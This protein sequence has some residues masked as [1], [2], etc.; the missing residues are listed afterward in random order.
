M[1]QDN[2]GRINRVGLSYDHERLEPSSSFPG[3]AEGYIDA[4]G[5]FL[6]NV[7]VDTQSFFE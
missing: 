3:K 2:G 7:T 4:Q 1:S 5:I 6:L